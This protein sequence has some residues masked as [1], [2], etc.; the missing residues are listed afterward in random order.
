MCV[1]VV[2]VH[3]CVFCVG[4]RPCGRMF[5]CWG[6]SRSGQLVPV[7]VRVSVC[8]MDEDFVCITLRTGK[9]V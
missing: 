8:V 9:S 5:V 7:S 4:V 1:Y 3:V 6:M 2:L